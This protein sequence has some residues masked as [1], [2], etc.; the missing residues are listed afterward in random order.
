MNVHYIYY[1][2]W[3]SSLCYFVTVAGKRVLL[4]C[5]M[6]ILWLNHIKGK[7]GQAVPLESINGEEKRDLNC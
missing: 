1:W 5:K 2:M 6:P 3:K 4:Y 7:C